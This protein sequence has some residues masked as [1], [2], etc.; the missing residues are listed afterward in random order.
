MKV[1]CARLRHEANMAAQVCYEKR[2]NYVNLEL[3]RNFFEKE[4]SAIEAESRCYYEFDAQGQ[5]SG[6][7]DDTLFILES[8]V[9]VLQIFPSSDVDS[10][11]SIMEFALENVKCAHDLCKRGKDEECIF[12]AIVVA[13]MA[14]THAIN[15]FPIENRMLLEEIKE[16]KVLIFEMLLRHPRCEW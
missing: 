12:G 15:S 6:P 2:E 8:H 5:C 1:D 3:L 7:D 16:M 11:T 4:K 10:T 14:V 13:L 9:G